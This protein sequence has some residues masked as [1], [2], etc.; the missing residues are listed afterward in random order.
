MAAL[1]SLMVLPF[2]LPRLVR[3][4]SLAPYAFCIATNWQH[5]PSTHRPFSLLIRI[6]QN[7]PVDR[8]HPRHPRRLRPRLP[9]RRQPRPQAD[10]VSARFAS[11]RSHPV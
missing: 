2:H 8:A 11:S 6:L 3:T 9:P 4:M 10:V 7:T 1:A 5:Q